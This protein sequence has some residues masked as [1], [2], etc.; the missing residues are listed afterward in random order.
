MIEKPPLQFA[1]TNGIRTG[2]YEAGPTTDKPP[3]VLCHSGPEIAFSWRYQIKALS[4]A[5]LRVIAPHQHGYGATA[6][7]LRCVMLTP[8]IAAGSR[9]SRDWVRHSPRQ[10]RN[11]PLRRWRCG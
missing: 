8:G 5:G 9:Q 10:D 4:E 11:L 7:T 6:M 2:F 1:Q 3:L